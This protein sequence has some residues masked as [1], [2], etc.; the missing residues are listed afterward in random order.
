[1]AM[2]NQGILLKIGIIFLILCF[3]GFEAKTEEGAVYK[4]QKHD[5]LKINIYPDEKQSVQREVNDL[6]MISIPLIGNI[7]VENFTVEEVQD[8]IKK[9][10]EYY[11]YN[12]EVIIELIS[13][14]R[15]KITVAGYKTEKIDGSSNLTNFYVELNKGDKLNDLLIKIGW[16]GNQ[17]LQFSRIIIL[18][19]QKKVYF[20]DLIDS[21]TD[22]LSYEFILENKDVVY[23][24]KNSSG[25]AKIIGYVNQPKNVNIPVHSGLTVLQAALEC[26][27]FR[28][29]ADLS[30]VKIN[31]YN[32]ESGQ[33][34]IVL[35]LYDEYNDTVLIANDIIE[36]PELKEKT[37]KYATFISAS[38]SGIITLD[39][40]KENTRLSDIIGKAKFNL[41]SKYNYIF[42]INSRFHPPVNAEFYKFTSDGDVTQNPLIYDGDIIT[43]K[44]SEKFTTEEKGAVSVLGNFV[45]QGRY[46]INE[47]SRLA[48]VLVKA[49]WQH[50]EAE[51]VSVLVIGANSSMAEYDINRFLYY[52]DSNH[53]PIVKPDDYIYVRSIQKN[54][55]YIVGQVNKPGYYELEND[56]T[57]NTLVRYIYK[58]GGP[59]ES[60]AMNRIKIVRNNLNMDVNLN[61]FFYAQNLDSDFKLQDKDIIYMPELQK[62]SFYV[63]GMV[64]KVGKYDS[65]KPVTVLEALSMAGGYRYTGKVRGAK[66]LRGARNNPQVIDVDILSSLNDFGYGSNIFLQEGDI[67][68]IPKSPITNL[69]DFLDNIVPTLRNSVDLGQSIKDY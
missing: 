13:I 59:K 31:R 43:A 29:E 64:N 55:V 22:Y 38:G 5:I 16:E 53:N 41:D 32:F 46:F 60:A 21:K 14:D 12:P 34:T 37:R 33:E 45:S 36:I 48:D 39:N 61:D 47:Y 3:L 24:E 28:P 10:L 11:Y 51:P 42:E 15:F 50:K 56:E 9:K 19:N 20:V 23:F 7:T 30:L 52:G 6:G 18:R 58:S 44:T 63:F 4:I 66:I 8:A 17:D 1:M 67:L 68:Y 49:N 54:K 65:D 26:G 25:T 2:K 40:W 57:L 27:G 62:F 35:N 69:K